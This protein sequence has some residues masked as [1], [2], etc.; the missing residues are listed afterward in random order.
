MYAAA[1]LKY[2]Q[3]RWKKYYPI[4][5]GSTAVLATLYN[6]GEIKP[7]HSNPVPR[8]FG[9]F[10]RANYEKVKKILN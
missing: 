8:E 5:D 3:D 7:P 2:F 9:N 4:I 1:Y 10:A 6:Q